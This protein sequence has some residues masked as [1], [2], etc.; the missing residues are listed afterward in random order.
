MDVDKMMHVLDP[1]ARTLLE[2]DFDVNPRNRLSLTPLHRLTILSQ[3]DQ[4]D[5][6]TK[7]LD[8]FDAF[9]NTSLHYAVMLRNE[10]AVKTLLLLGADPNLRQQPNPEEEAVVTRG[11]AP[12][13]LACE[14]YFLPILQ[15]LLE[16]KALDCNSYSTSGLTPLHVA[17]RCFFFEAVSVLLSTGKVDVNTVTS[18]GLNALHLIGKPY[19]HRKC[20]R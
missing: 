12:L 10:R 15:L 7:F 3:C 1:V 17:C 8:A 2:L 9:G 11:F 6:F 16:D 18:T 14:S 5:G 19:S 13:H 20:Q 4:M